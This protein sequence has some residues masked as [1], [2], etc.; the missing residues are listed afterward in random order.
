METIIVINPDGLT[1]KAKWIRLTNSQAQKMSPVDR[2]WY[3]VDKRGKNECWGWLSYKNKDGYGIFKHSGKATSTHRYSY[4]LHNGEIPNNLHVLHS[5]DN[6]ACVN[7]KHIRL[8]THQENM[9]DRSARK[10]TSPRA[11]TETPVITHAGRVDMVK[12]FIA[13]TPKEEL[14]AMINSVRGYGRDEAIIEQ[15]TELAADYFAN[16]GDGEKTRQECFIAGANYKLSSKGL[17]D[18]E[19]VCNLFDPDKIYTKQYIIE[20]INSL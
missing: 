11:V 16:Y 1:A 19:A 17:V 7:P 18:R 3:N 13:E 8:G 20:L 12:K 6:P 2:F 10:R 5:C 15:S 14:D 4:I 9:D